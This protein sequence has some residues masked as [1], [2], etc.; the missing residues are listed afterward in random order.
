MKKEIIISIVM[1]TYNSEKTI[2]MSL[3]SI[4]IQTMSAEQIE[5]LVVDGGSTDRTVEIAQS[6]GAVLLD[7]PKKLPE[8]AKRIGV[9]AANGE[10]IMI[11]DSDEQL[12]SED[13][14]ERRISFLR[15]HAEAHC[16]L[17]GYMPPPNTPACGHYISK[18]GDPFSAF[19]Y[20]WY[21]G[22]NM[23][24]I[25]KK[26]ILHDTEGYLGFFSD[27]DIIPIGDS[28]TMLE[29]KYVLEQYGELLESENTSTIFQKLV[30]DTHY[31]AHL[32]GDYVFHY[33]KSEFRTFLNKLK[34]RVINNVFDVNGS[35]F[36][37]REQVAKKPSRKKYLY[38]LYCLSVILPAFDGVRMC[39]YY[40]KWI[41]LCHIFFSWYVLIQII[42]QYSKKII[43]KTSRNYQ[44][45]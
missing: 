26:D 17:G 37:A 10:Y 43:G 45:G 23:G 7:N 3:D 38:P 20:N 19:A 2:A 30:E 14:F 5:I 22:G 11:M 24:L 34:F 8:I 12:P 44:Y 6:Y 21:I 15:K 9:K 25:Q 36:A 13:I 33:T 35:G 39:L 1:A 18:V 28:V 42:V 16:L 32:K 40:K 27:G 31:V 41:Y 29:R 4:K